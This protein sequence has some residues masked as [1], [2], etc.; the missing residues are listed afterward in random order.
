M[1]TPVDRVIDMAQKGYTD[2]QIIKQLKQD[3]FS[4]RQINDA[5]NQAKV[6]LELNKSL[7][8]PR[9][10]QQTQQQEQ[11]EETGQFVEGQEVPYPQEESPE[12]YPYQYP[13]Y[14][15]VGRA[16]A[17]DVEELVNEIIEEKWQEFKK[18]T[19][20]IEELKDVTENSIKNFDSRLKRTETILNKLSSAAN[21]KFKEHSQEI[22][23][24]KAEMQ[25]LKETIQKIMSPL[26]SKVK[27]ETGML[28]I[29][30]ESKGH[31]VVKEIVKKETKT[32]TR[33]KTS[34]SK[35]GKKNIE[36]LF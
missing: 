13:S 20:N 17:E 31:P 10:E 26:M 19:S 16:N 24:L 14:Q 30:K 25:A 32:I 2:V 9:P 33:V 23:M 36:D 22:K 5:F 11:N 18:R 7:E 3:G 21:D 27:Q 4:P 34:K 15:D 6:K 35:K 28:D 8:A 12:Q 1:E 29:K